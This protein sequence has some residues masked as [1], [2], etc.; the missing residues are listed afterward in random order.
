MA[1]GINRG[2]GGGGVSPEP[3][4]TTLPD[5]LGRYSGSTN[6]TSTILVPKIDSSQV[7]RITGKNND[8]SYYFN[9]YLYVDFSIDG[10]NFVEIYAS[11]VRPFPVGGAVTTLNIPLTAVVGHS[12][13]FRIRTTNDSR[14]SID[15]SYIACV[16]ST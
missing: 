2:L 1:L 4:D 10:S 16:V 11:S 8:T 14:G 6:K 13:Y 9:N 12:G 3:L 15:I 7:L 5:L